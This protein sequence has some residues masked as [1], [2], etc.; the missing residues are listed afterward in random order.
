MDQKAMEHADLTFQQEQVSAVVPRPIHQAAAKQLMAAMAPAEVLCVVVTP[1]NYKKLGL[2]FKTFVAVIRGGDQQNLVFYLDKLKRDVFTVLQ[3]IYQ[4]HPTSMQAIGVEDPAEFLA[5]ARKTGPGAAGRPKRNIYATE[6]FATLSHFFAR[7]NISPICLSR[8]KYPWI[9]L[10]ARLIK[11]AAEDIPKQVG[12]VECAANSAAR[13]LILCNVDQNI[14][15]NE[16]W[17]HQ[18][19]GYS[20]FKLRCILDSDIYE[21]HAFPIGFGVLALATLAAPFTAGASLGFT[22]GLA[23]AGLATASASVMLET[24]P[25]PWTLSKHIN[26]HI[27][28]GCAFKFSHVYS[29]AYF[30]DCAKAI[31]SD[32]TDADPVLVFIFWAPTSW[33]YANVVA[34]KGYCSR[35]HSRPEGFVI[36]ETHSSLDYR[37][38]DNLEHIMYNQ[39]KFNTKFC[40]GGTPNNYTIIRFHRRK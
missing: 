1:E 24:G 14:A 27:P 40:L 7:L 10:S 5:L 21:K 9:S 23:G 11:K 29:Y 22:L 12:D 19:K 16:N 25:S 15:T 6:T 4:Q 36:L 20:D 2:D 26:H 32:I 39:Y 3:S 38:Y 33:H 28:D 34:V 13:A 8:G 17:K 30:S 18:T 31:A 37:T 35:Y